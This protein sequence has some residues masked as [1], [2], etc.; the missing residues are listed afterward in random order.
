MRGDE[1]ALGCADTPSLPS[2]PAFRP[3]YSVAPSREYT[4]T[5]GAPRPPGKFQPQARRVAEAAGA[6]RPPLPQPGLPGSSGAGGAEGAPATQG[7]A[8]GCGVRG[9]PRVGGRWGL[10]QRVNLSPAAFY[11]ISFIS[12]HS[13]CLLCRVLPRC[14]GEDAPAS[15]HLVGP[16]SWPGRS[17][18]PGK[19][20]I[21][22]TPSKSHRVRRPPENAT[23]KATGVERS[24]KPKEEK[25]VAPEEESPQKLLNHYKSRERQC[26]CI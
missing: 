8:G 13:T 6:G 15:P 17:G 11:F 20:G 18:A 26:F 1:A 14:P 24:D 16:R 10:T 19:A 23:T 12:L 9:E 2:F 21:W 22:V 7:P 3:S 4:G 5:G 25:P